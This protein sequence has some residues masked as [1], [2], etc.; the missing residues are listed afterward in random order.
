M[1]KLIMVGMVLLL[2]VFTATASLAGGTIKLAVMEP[3]SGTFKDIGD[4]YLEGVQYAA[5]VLNEQ[6]GI[7][8]MQVEVIPVDSELKPA[9][10]TRKA[11][12]LM[13]KE[14]VKYFCGGTG[15]SV[16]GAMVALTGKK[17]GLFYTYGMAAASMTGAKCSKTFF[18]A[19][20]NTDTQSYALANWVAS[21]GFTKVFTVAQD[22]S[23]GQQAT[24]AFI[25][26]LKELNPKAEIVGKVLHPIGTKDFAPYVS[27]IINS[28]A[29]VVFTSNWGSDLT[30][31]L[32]Q[33]KPLGLKAKFACYYLNDENA[34][35]A[36]ANDEAVVGSVAAEVYM[37]TIPG[38]A[39]KKFVEGFKKAKGYYPTWLRGKA[40]LATMFWAEAVK[41]AGSAKVSDVIK[42]W[43]GLTYDGPAGK[44]VMRA[45]DHQTQQPIWIAPVVA[46][47]PY[48]K[49]AYVGEAGMVPASKVDVP[50]AQTG[51][52]GLAK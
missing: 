10:A 50:C 36:V 35:T 40:Y 34:I 52:K 23:F 15:S 14:G 32:K 16:G 47:S 42:A 2:A 41:K 11:T 13:I 6:G 28:G 48:F 25:K 22:Y 30:L 44:W 18:R 33:A 51:C 27:Q 17:G 43:E 29:E 26:K 1:R 49:H 9:I 8:G 19:C 38:E 37:I 21:Q 12:K 7:N 20:A 3:L 24:E 5:Q 46:K 31:L 45:C 39:N 4:R